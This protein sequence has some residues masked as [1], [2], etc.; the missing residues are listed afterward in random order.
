MPFLRPALA[1]TQPSVPRRAL[2][3]LAPLPI[4]ALVAGCISTRG[5]APAES[6]P[7]PQDSARAAG[8]AGEASVAL[9]G[10]A[11]WTGY[12]DAE[13]SGWIDRGL[14]GNPNLKQA[15]ARVAS[16]RA[17]ADAA[18]GAL[19]PSL[20]VTV[21]S[22]AERFSK[23]GIFPPPLGG[24]SY[25]LNDALLGAN[26]DLDLFGK[27]AATADAA[28]LAAQA[29]DVDRQAA[30]AELATSIA[31]TWFAI[32]RLQRA[33]EIAIA[34]RAQREDIVK[35]VGQR[36][37]AG[38]DTRVELRQAEGAV[39]QVNVEV[40]Q[41]DEQVALLKHQL[42]TLAGQPPQ[43][44]DGVAA[45]LP[46]VP[47]MAAPARLPLELLARRADIA[48]AL[49]RVRAAGREADAAR[50]D[51]Y[52]NINLS[53]FAGF[54]AL[55]LSHL[56]ETSSKTWGIEPALHLPIFDAGRLRANLAE[57][58][59][60]A[61]AAVEAYNATVLG[62]ARETADALTS[63]TALD[64]ERT[65]QK[66]ATEAAE[67]AYD[68]AVVRYRAGLGT[69]LTVLT[70][71]ANVLV[72]RRLASDLDARVADL[73]VALVRAL[74]GGW[75]ATAATAGAAATNP[76]N[77]GAAASSDATPNPRS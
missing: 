63:I 38:L 25:T 54:N 20:G 35:L 70:A 58:R 3:R 36:V 33:R 39:P 5:L 16:A 19:S 59:A 2:R 51:F 10:A 27:A 73:D 7:T 50:A 15:A 41:I 17:L 46:A 37:N 18:R 11:W 68:L 42:A 22:T 62:A 21:D 49:L 9:P 56:L 72:Q 60:D 13:L 14:A 69:Y 55:G 40:E 34:T 64:R 1:G 44:A 43:A 23:N 30:R 76:T 47:L 24:N 28:T 32:G 53:A 26:W 12:G 71:D 74:G 45:K 31:R 75:S 66:L 61:T 48:A 65:Q 77:S 67:S 6:L 57:R 29:A 52:P 8:L 4:A